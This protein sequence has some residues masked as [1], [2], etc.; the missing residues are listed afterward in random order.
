MKSLE[1]VRLADWLMR[2]VIWAR[3]A[4]SVFMALA[5]PCKR[6]ALP[7]VLAVMSATALKAAFVRRVYTQAE[8]SA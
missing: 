8:S 6:P 7:S 5:K 4:A 3:R 1:A 2:A